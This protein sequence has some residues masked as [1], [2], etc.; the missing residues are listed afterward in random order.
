M[1]RN[2]VGSIFGR[3]CII[4]AHL[5]KIKLITLILLKY[6]VVAFNNI[7]TGGSRDRMVDGFITTYAITTNVMSSNPA[8]VRCTGYNIM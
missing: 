4:I 3:S 8:Q 1:N 5:V 2:L 6:A 7:K